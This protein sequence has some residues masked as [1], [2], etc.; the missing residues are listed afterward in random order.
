MTVDRTLTERLLAVSASAA[1]TAVVAGSNIASPLLPIYRDSLSLSTFVIS[2]LFSTYLIVLVA[3]FCLLA[4][5]QLARFSSLM[6][7]SAVI[8]QIIASI[9]LW[10]GS[11]DVQWLF[12]GRGLGGAAVGLATGST[13]TLVVAAV[14]E[15]GRTAVATSAIAG[16]AVGLVAATWVSATSS[17]AD[18]LLYQ[19][20]IVLLA[21]VLCLVV[22]SLLTSRNL[23]RDALNT[24]NSRDY[25]RTPPARTTNISRRELVA[26][27][28]IGAAGWAVGG[29]A[30]GS[31]PSAIR[32]Q[33]A[34]DS[35]LVSMSA[36]LP[37]MCVAWISPFVMRVLRLKLSSSQTMALIAG[38]GVFI[39][40][41]MST[42]Q[43][44]PVLFG[45]IAWGLG[46]GAAYARGLRCVTHGMTPQQ[47][48]RAT[49]S[50]AA[51]AY[52]FTALVIV[53]TGAVTSALGNTP[54]MSY[55]VA[56]LILLSLTVISLQNMQR[57]LSPTGVT[58]PTCT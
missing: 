51:F 17:Q 16:S 14:G 44:W 41:G 46:Q 57:G 26:A 5:T 12:V 23:I 34:T 32:Q 35:V 25:P 8:L 55:A 37:L 48:G 39:A 6:L 27:Y 19:L 29:L 4:W 11:D 20:H 2:A 58:R 18:Q 36:A 40:V 13:A 47:Q 50:Y 21:A 1:Y 7:P 54:G 15:R 3:F 31:I 45:G 33:F 30:T 43:L 38:G 28:G 10:A 52:A 42:R 56:I 49:S 22:A 9:A 24:A 53:T